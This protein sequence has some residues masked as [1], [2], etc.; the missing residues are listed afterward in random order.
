MK[1]RIPAL[2]T[3]FAVVMT[4]AASVFSLGVDD[5]N[6]ESGIK[7][8][9]VMVSD[10]M[11]DSAVALSRWYKAYNPETNKADQ[12]VALAL[13]ELVSGKV[14]TYWE[15]ADGN[16]GAITDSAPAA[17]AMATGH[18]T[19]DK[20]IS[21]TPDKE[22]RPLATTLEAAKS[23]GK[24]TGIVATSNIQH[25]TPA[26]FSSHYPDRSKYAII[27]EQQVY[28]DMDV[29]LGGGS[30]YLTP[31]YR[32]D[33]EDLIK[34]LRAM[35]YNYVTTKDEMNAVTDGKLWGMF[36]EDA[37]AYD[38]DR[39]M[40]TNSTQPS[41]AEMTKKSIELLSQN[42]NGF[43]LMVEGSK[44]DWA[45]HAN[46]PIGCISDVLAFDNAVRV[47]LSYA[48]ARQDTMLIILTD[49]GTGGITIGNTSTDSSYSS[50][51][52]T[53]FIAPLSKATLTPEGVAALFNKERTNIKEVVGQ[54]LGV[55]DLTDEE[56]EAI[57]EAD[58]S[59]M[60]YAIG[61]IISKRAGIGWTTGGHT[62]EDITLYTYLP[63]NERI[64][65]LINN[66]DVAKATANAWG[67]DLDALTAQIFVNA[68]KAF[69]AKGARTEVSEEVNSN[70]PVLI[71]RKG[72][73][74][75]EMP[76]SK[77]YVL[78]NGRKV[79]TNSVTVQTG[80]DFYVSL[81]VVELMG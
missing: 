46:D 16:P 31:P 39:R 14:R 21:V 1:R 36:A 74:V 18:K 52:V 33:G 38:F 59:S 71:A 44:V 64:V 17:S 70:N 9:I 61:P 10:G 34:E 32:E 5:I 56:I 72:N 60:N 30:M 40:K 22:N 42:D 6:T 73:T 2:L 49:H 35:N 80:A 76:V 25:A 19:H 4:Q 41:L 50:D 20:H 47:A 54:Y 45:N 43:F 65:G 24:S 12:S 57:K 62:G 67:T 58:L 15:D 81:E 37:M 26:G 75:I 55:T 48:K 11:S 13:D 53:K 63:Q 27:G 3:A 28:Q 79:K 69:Q 66:T 8:V 78:V 68:A 77:N 7:N 51:P 23:L 29:V